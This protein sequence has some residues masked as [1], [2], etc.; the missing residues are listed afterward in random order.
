MS[1]EARLEHLE[2]RFRLAIFAFAATA[3]ALVFVLMNHGDRLD[4][5]SSPSFLRLE[6]LRLVDKNGVD[7]VIIAGDLP[8]PS[9]NGELRQTGRSMAGILMFDETNTERS[10]YGTMNGY[11]NALITLDAQGHQTFMLLAEPGGGSFFRQWEGDA[12]VTLGVTDAP[13]VTLMDGEQVVFAEP[14]DNEW[15]TRG[16]RGE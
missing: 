8:E 11:A 9:I 3:V 4:A 1:V 2:N 10:G 14:P 15:T 6:E 12:S 5:A 13:F 7:R 16:L